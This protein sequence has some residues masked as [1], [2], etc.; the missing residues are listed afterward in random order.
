M[1][2]LQAFFLYRVG[3]LVRTFRAFRATDY[4]HPGLCNTLDFKGYLISRNQIMCHVV[5]R[6]TLAFVGDILL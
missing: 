4:L 1:L 2:D 5:P 6:N 3:E